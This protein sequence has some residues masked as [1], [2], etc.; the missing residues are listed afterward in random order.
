MRSVVLPSAVHLTIAATRDAPSKANT[1]QVMAFS[2]VITRGCEGLRRARRGP[3]SLPENLYA[4]LRIWTAMNSLFELHPQLAADC[5]LLGQLGNAHLLLHRNASV[6]WFILVPEVAQE[7]FLELDTAV[8]AKLLADCS[9][10]GA[11]IK[12]R[13]DCPKLNFGVIGNV[14]PQLHLHA[15]GTK[16]GGR[17]LASSGV[18]ESHGRDALFRGRSDRAQEC[19]GR[20]TRI[21]AKGV[22][23]TF[24]FSA[25]AEK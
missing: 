18:G 13:F 21:A 25:T 23:G 24:Y 4:A 14:V 3:E 8:Q 10:L 9:R 16:R 2:C 6:P 7:E 12:R 22:K 19:V 5:H 15:R 17:L 11:F 20:R 1:T